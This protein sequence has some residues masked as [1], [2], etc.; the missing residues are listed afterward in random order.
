MI[1]VGGGYMTIEEFVDKHIEKEIANIKI[2]MKRDQKDV[3]EIVRDLT[4]KYK[5]KH[6]T[7]SI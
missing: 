3:S 5:Y 4:K 2:R 1:R 7:T 6:F